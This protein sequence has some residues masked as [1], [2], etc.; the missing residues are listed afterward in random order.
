MKEEDLYMPDQHYHVIDIEDH[1]NHHHRSHS[2]SKGHKDRHN[3]NERKRGDGIVS[4]NIA[5]TVID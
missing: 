4:G 3:L 5:S 2:M 1:S